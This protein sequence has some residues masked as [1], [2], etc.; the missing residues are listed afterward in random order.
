MEVSWPSWS[1]GAGLSLES[2][3]YR[4]TVVWLNVSLVFAQVHAP[5]GRI[6]NRDRTIE[7]DPRWCLSLSREFGLVLQ[8][9]GF[10]KS[11]YWPFHAETLE[12]LRLGRDGTWRQW[13]YEDRDDD[14]SESHP[15]TYVLESGE[16]QHRTATIRHSR[17]VHGRHILSRLGWPSRVE[18]GIEISFDGEVGEDTGSWKGGCIG[19]SYE[20]QPGETA[21]Q[22]LR[23]MERERRF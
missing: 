7:D 22:A 1:L 4:Y 11:W 15:Y 21:L 5:V 6:G 13:K 17:R 20:M 10:W 3:E 16:V 19:C 23:R 14:W 12:S 8:W 18:D 2:G 9:G